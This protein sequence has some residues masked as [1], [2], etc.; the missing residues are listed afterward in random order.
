M[1]WLMAIALAATLLMV[2][3]GR[4]LP[5]GAPASVAARPPLVVDPVK[6]PR[7]GALIVTSNDEVRLT[8]GA[9]GQFHTSVAINGQSVPMLVD[10]GADGVALT[11]ETARALGIYVDPSGFTEVARGAGGTVKGMRV[12]LPELAIGGRRMSDVQAVVL[13]G[14]GTNLLGQSVLRQMGSVELKGDEMLLR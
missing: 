9:D 3:V 6:P 7:T 5:T 4:L 14:L 1:R 8:R 11:V 13:D 2:A 10:T 12:T